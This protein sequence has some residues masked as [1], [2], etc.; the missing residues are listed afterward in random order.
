MGITQD[1]EFIGLN[2][3]FND[4]NDILYLFSV[5][6]YRADFLCHKEN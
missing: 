2:I 6:L 4:I 3:G 1:V 5:S